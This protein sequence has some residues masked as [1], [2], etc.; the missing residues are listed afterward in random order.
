MKLKLDALS[1]LLSKPQWRIMFESIDCFIR[2][3]PESEQRMVQEF[4]KDRP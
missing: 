3:L 2:C 1:V 4:V